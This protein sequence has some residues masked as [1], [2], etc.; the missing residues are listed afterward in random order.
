MVKALREGFVYSGQYSLFRRRRHG[1]SSKRFPHTKFIVFSQNHDQVGNR[2]KGDRLSTLASFEALKLAAGIV[3]LSPSLPLLFMGEEYGEEAPFHYFFSHSDQKLIEEIRRGRREEFLPLEWQGDPPDP[4]SEETFQRSKI[5]FNLHRHGKHGTLFELYRALMRCRKEIPSL[6][7]LRKTEMDAEGCS[8]A[9]AIV[10]RR[11][12]GEDRILGIFNFSEATANVD[13]F[14]EQGLWQKAL[15]S[16]DSKWEGPGSVL[17]ESLRS[18]G[19]KFP[20]KIN[21]FSFALYHR[22]NSISAFLEA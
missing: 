9:P 18:N 15:D 3:I 22:L 12:C 1:S 20:F 19:A 10:M 6:S 4:Q 5:D 21:P 17:P 8:E 11:R 7:H 2:M 14:M 16:S 13:V